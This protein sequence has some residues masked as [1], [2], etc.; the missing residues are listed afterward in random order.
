MNDNE[1]KAALKELYACE[2]GTWVGVPDPRL[3][4]RCQD[5]INVRLFD[6]DLDF[7]VWFSCLVRDMYLSDAAL[8]RGAGLEDLCEFWDWFDRHM[9]TGKS[10]DVT[11]T[12]AS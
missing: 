12:R 8:A 11:L 4:A 1:L 9:W 7:R 10:A 6:E 3:R 2:S 5:A